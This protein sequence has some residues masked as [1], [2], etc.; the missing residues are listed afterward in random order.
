MSIVEQ[1]PYLAGADSGTGAD[2]PLAIQLLRYMVA[3]GVAFVADV[4]VLALLTQGLG[5]HYLIAA[6]VA[7]LLGMAINYAISVR[8]VFKYRSVDNPRYEQLLFL[9]IG[10][11]GLL[12]NELVLLVGTH[13]L[14]WFYLHSKLL[15]TTVVLGWNFGARKVILFTAPRDSAQCERIGS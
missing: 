7:F 9:T 14:H 4:A 3:G 13:W 2:S 10:L 15:A 5:V 6:A 8:W 12:M 11:I 1:S